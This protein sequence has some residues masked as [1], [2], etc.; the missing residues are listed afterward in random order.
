MATLGLLAHGAEVG[1]A[2]PR[3]S[4]YVHK[5][6]TDR[7]SGHLVGHLLWPALYLRQHRIFLF[8]QPYISPCRLDFL[9][10]HKDSWC[11][12]EVDGSGHDTS[13]D[14]KRPDL[15]DMSVS[16]VVTEQV[17][18]PGFP[19]YFEMLVCRLLRVA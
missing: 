13:N 15:L 4:G 3:H 10:G 19:R 7:E 11:N 16:R 8:Q 1:A 9:A 14:F 2:S 5:P 6:I 18:Q 12:L 17:L